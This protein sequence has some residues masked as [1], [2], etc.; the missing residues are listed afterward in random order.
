MVKRILDRMSSPSESSTKRCAYPHRSSEDYLPSSCFRSP[1]PSRRAQLVEHFDVPITLLVEKPEHP[2]R[3]IIHRGWFR[4]AI[5]L[6]RETD[7]SCIYFTRT[8]I[9]SDIKYAADMQYILTDLPESPDERQP[10]Y[11]QVLFRSWICSFIMLT[12]PS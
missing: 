9:F 5:K 6:S 11:A 4:L 2:S 1:E 3:G 12:C 8:P 10:K 7:S